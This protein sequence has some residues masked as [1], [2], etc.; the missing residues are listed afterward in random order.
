MADVKEK[1]EFLKEVKTNPSRFLPIFDHAWK[2]FKKRDDGTE[3]YDDPQYNLGWDAGTLPGNRPYFMECWATSGITMLTYFISAQGLENMSTKDLV[4]ILEDA[5]LVRITD[6]QHPRAE[7]IK[8]N[9]SAGNEFWSVN[10]TV[11]DENGTYT[12]GGQCYPFRY[13]N[14]F[15]KQKT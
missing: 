15:N 1:I 11:G 7:T 10:I 4:K 2:T 14:E 13:L 5:N 3:W 12:Q 6:H 9:D 8:V